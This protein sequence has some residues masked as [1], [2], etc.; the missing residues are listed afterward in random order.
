VTKNNNAGLNTHTDPE[1][2]ADIEAINHIP[3]V[4][5]LLE[6][7]CRT[8]GMG[9]AAIA[10]VTE[11]KWIALCV[12]D[13]ISFGLQPGGELKLETTI[14]NEIRQSGQEVIIDHVAEDAAFFNHHTPAMYGFQSYIS[15]PIIRKDGS[16][17]GTLCAID[18]KPANLHTSAIT[19]MF[20]LFA[21]LIATHLSAFDT[22][23]VLADTNG[24]L[25]KTQKELQTSVQ[26][27]T[28]SKDKLQQAIDTGNMGT[29]S[30]NPVTY[31]VTLSD[32]VKNLFG[33]PLDEEVSIERIVETM[34]PA[35][36]QT[37]T[38]TLKNA[39]ENHQDSDIEY[40]IYNVITKE[41]KWVRATGRLFYHQNGEL[42][43]YSGILM[44]I[45]DRK[46]DE[47]RQAMLAAIIESSEDAIISKTLDGI[48]TSW[49]Q[50][51]EKLFGY[52]ETEAVGKHITI[53]IPEDRLKEEQLIISKVRNSERI[54]HFETIR[55][56]KAGDEIPISLTVSPILNEQGKIIGA[57]KIVRDISKQKIADE[58]L[59]SYAERLE[60][61]N[62]IGQ[63]ISADLDMQG[64]LQK[65]TDATTQL[66]GASFGAFFHNKVNEQGESYMLYTLSGAPREAFEKFGMPRNTAVFASTFNGEGIV[67][68]DD[69]TK[70]PR[71]GKNLPHHGMP[72]GH[73][74]V[75]SYLAVPVK[76]KTGEVIGGLFFGHKDPGVFKKEHEQLVVGVAAQAS[77]ALDNAKLYEEI[78]ML[79]AKKDEFIGLASHELKTPVTSISGYLQIIKR[80]LTDDDRS[81]A[82][83]SKALQQVNKLT[84]LISDL[85]DVSKIQTGKLPLSYTS[86]DLVGLL[87]DVAE[88]MQQNYVGHQIALEYD[89]RPIMLN[90]DNERMEQVI[91]NLITN[92]VK[93]SPG[94]SRV[95]IRATISGKKIRVSVQDFGIGIAKDQQ[96][97]IFSRF[98]RVENLAAHMS[99]LGI[100]LY[101]CHE[102]I[103]RH[104]G[105]MWVDSELG[106]GA[107]FYFELPTG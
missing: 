99:G 45:T 89:E 54:E 23:K 90:A 26:Q 77:V 7:V 93:Y 14:C 38:D 16:F 24:Q 55:K 30:I 73:L 76:S 39:I 71:Y 62:S 19:G 94:A 53:V 88:M 64:I 21:N 20:R 75:V 28:E 79:N 103:N 42:S 51:A 15:V 10:R 78:K 106:K 48:I 92:A 80:G 43:E 4:S 83:V 2:Q 67:R 85:L 44:D 32:Y 84:A 33:F 13:E 72:K 91:I 12:R 58:R 8:T 25:E 37:L 3:M 104:K 81:K 96:Q 17:F 31:Q 86:F 60:I 105:K 35:Y 50:S 66:T 98:Y 11:N 63:T 101:I 5:T 29:W 100:G 49:N 36:Q 102:I 57:S 9:F 52:T 47:D 6:V 68:V 97:R 65:V 107:T 82:F 69:I 56:T 61:L 1:I 40:P 59:Q 70:D 18:P 95:V 87:A 27:L 74:P 46:Q 41:R 34:D 22:N